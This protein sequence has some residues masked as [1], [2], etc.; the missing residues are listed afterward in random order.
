MKKYAWYMPGGSIR[1]DSDD[2]DEVMEEVGAYIAEGGIDPSSPKV[3]PCTKIT[4]SSLI[5]DETL[6]DCIADVVANLPEYRHPDGRPVGPAEKE[7][8]D[9]D[10]VEDLIEALLEQAASNID[11]MVMDSEVS[12]RVTEEM[13]DDLLPLLQ[14]FLGKEAV[15]VRCEQVDYLLA[16]W[17]DKHIDHDPECVCEGQDALPREYRNGAWGRAKDGEPGAEIT[18][19]TLPDAWPWVWCAKGIAHRAPTYKQARLCAEAVLATGGMSR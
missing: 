18:H 15:L 16:A 17:A 3:G 9:R 12:Q 7:M 2:F 4:G 6:A 8:L 11:E 1:G 14:R 19:E 5:C 13:I 10:V